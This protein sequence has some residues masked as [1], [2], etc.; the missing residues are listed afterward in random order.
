MRI[1]TACVALLLVF[2]MAAS[3]EAAESPGVYTVVYRTPAHVKYSKPEVF[4]GFAQDLWSHLKSKNVPLVG[5]RGVIETESQISVESMLSRAK[6]LKATSVLFVTVDRPFTKWIKVTVQ[7]Y[8]LD[9]KLQWSEEAS[10]GGSLTGK[11]G[12]KKTLERIEVDIERRLNT[13][14]LPVSKEEFAGK[15]AGEEKPALKLP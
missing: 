13:G 5:E 11:G 4:H 6:L 14:G 7:S 3:L 2:Q 10:D 8:A 12:Y 9:G 15:K 1:K